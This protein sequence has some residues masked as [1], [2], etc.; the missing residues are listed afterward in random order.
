MIL[1][2][3]VQTDSLSVHDRGLMYGDGVFRTLRVSHGVALCWQRHYRKLLADCAALNINCPSIAVLS[4]EVEAVTK[5]NPECVV[6]III[7]RG[8]G[9]RGYRVAPGATPNRVVMSSPLPDYP[10]SHYEQGVKVRICDL[11]LG[12]QPRLAG[13]KH[14]NRL[15]NV[16]ARQ[17][18]NDEAI[19]EG[20]L[21][22]GEGH[23]ICGTMTNLF[24]LKGAELC[25]PDLSRCGLAGVQRERV[26]ERA[27]K[28][29]IACKVRAISLPELLRADE[30]FLTNSVI[31]VWQIREIGEKRWEPG[32]FAPMVRDWL[33][34][35]CD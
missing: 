29:G 27:G 19:A 13:I 30:A 34:R 18:W 7:T 24:T 1:V 2:N 26:L 3:G 15:E 31:G 23:V 21:L 12:L 6:K 4:M 22:D 25:T 32:C 33:D 35:D 9:T 11:R 10:A 14:L 16:L 28:A 5:A 8:A 17:E 20:L